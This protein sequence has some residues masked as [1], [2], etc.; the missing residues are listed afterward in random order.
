MNEELLIELL[1]PLL[2]FNKFKK[3]L[4]K[5]S[6]SEFDDA[7]NRIERDISE[8]GEDSNDEDSLFTLFSDL[9]EN[10]EKP[11]LKVALANFLSKGLTKTDIFTPEDEG[12]DYGHGFMKLFLKRRELVKNEDEYSKYTDQVKLGIKNR[13]KAH[14]YYK[15][16]LAKK[17]KKLRKEHTSKQVKELNSPESK[18]EAVEW[19]KNV[20]DL[21]SLLK[22]LRDYGFIE[23][24]WTKIGRFFKKEGELISGKK[25]KNGIAAIKSDDNRLIGSSEIQNLQKDFKNLTG[26]KKT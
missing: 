8:I 23:P 18:I 6:Q 1:E 12:D 24:E 10:E 13:K 9:W 16:T 26:A 5:L 7:L 14:D 11:P 22:L 17:I 21:Y 19:K 4:G 2:D 15:K 3:I 25:I 20:T